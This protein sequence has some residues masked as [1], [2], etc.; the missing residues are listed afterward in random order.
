MRSAF[1]KLPLI[2]AVLGLS[3]MSLSINA[4]RVFHHP[5]LVDLS[6]FDSSGR[7]LNWIDYL[8]FHL[9]ETADELPNK[10]LHLKSSKT[11]SRSLFPQIVTTSL[12]AFTARVVSPGSN[13][14]FTSSDVYIPLPGY[15]ASLSLLHLF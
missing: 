14:S 2:I 1:I 7:P 13:S 12:I 8:F 10:P 9:A 4:E 11:L 3:L 6:D 15:Y 5:L